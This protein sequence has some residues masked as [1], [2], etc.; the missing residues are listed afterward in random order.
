M[1]AALYQSLQQGATLLTA[2]RYLAHVLTQ[3]YAQAAQAQGL[4]VWLTPRILP[5]STY[6]RLAC[7]QQRELLVNSPRLLSEQQALAVWEHVV[8]EFNDARP[9]SDRLLNPSQAA[10]HAQRSWQRLHQYQL[11]LQRLRDYPIEETRVFSDWA[12]RF[13][14]R[15]ADKG[16]LDSARFASFLSDQD[17]Q[18]D[19]EL[20]VYG[21]DQITPEMQHLLQRWAAQGASIKQ[22]ELEKKQAIASVLAVPEAG[23]ELMQAA[24]WARVRIESGMQRVA[25]VVPGLNQQATQVQRCFT[26]VFAPAQR[27]I[28]VE[29]EP[30]AFHVVATPALSGYPL[31]HHALLLLELMQGKVDALV[32]GQLLRSPYIA[33]YEDEA[34]VRALLDLKVR[35]ESLDYWFSHDLEQ[36][37]LKRNCNQLAACLQAASQYL[38]SNQQRALPSEWTERLTMLL[39]LSGWSRGRSLDSAEQQTL[40]KFHQLLGELSALDELLGRIDFKLAISTLHDACNAEHFAPESVD[41]AVT[42][43]DVD[44]IA[45]MHFDAIWVMGLHA[46]EWP[47]APEP[48]P[49]LPV[50][51]QRSYGI[52]EASAGQ[53]LQLARHKLQR[54]VNAADEVILSWPEKD[55][56]A[57]L[58]RSPLLDIYDNGVIA[59]VRSGAVPSLAQQIF[60]ARP[61]LDVYSDNRAP[62]QN[63]GSAK[64]G[65]RILELQSRCPFRAQ[66]ELRLH[67]RPV[68]SV[69]PA[70]EAT[71]RGKLV[72]AVL[73]EVWRQL[74][75]SERLRE[76]VLDDFYVEVHAIALRHAKEVIGRSSVHR[77]RLAELEAELST[78]WI[79]N[80]LQLE[81]ARTPFRVQQTE[82]NETYELAGMQI[83]IQ[84]DRIDELSDGSR[85]LIDYKTGTGNN[86]GDWLD[87]EPGRP[88]SP[89]LPL[90]ALAHQQQL[91]GI[92]FAVLAP[93]KT[94]FRGLAATDTIAT[95]IKDYTQLRPEQKP[96]GI[97]T[98]EALLSHWKTVLNE[99]AHQYLSGVADVDPLKN[100]CTY[101]HLRSLCRVHEL[102]QGI[103][104]VEEEGGDA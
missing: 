8:N 45:G 31:V 103:E 81:S 78:Q 90:Y 75:D 21:F 85:L 69:S 18:P 35:D 34:S 54:L 19:T 14:S 95:G 2:S 64:G 38:K 24:Q 71:D 92:T 5:W 44:S 11:P 26:N 42:V 84:L 102:L 47:P 27:R 17:F 29:H 1:D 50:E 79:M 4:A 67:A 88:R 58:R 12:E 98:W 13:I 91:S 66:A 10:R 86:T 94:E 52:P 72:H 101:C 80:L 56:D 99:L 96:D 9:Q 53:C 100:E 7:Q 57:E 59:D 40:V 33:G 61:K 25:V 89:Q 36:L 32:I 20:L 30:V 3:E 62:Q 65:T 82:Q 70:V 74:K 37:A 16:W 23:V 83:R 43:I 63:P 46:G 55:A 48:D 28:N 104:Q 93:G 41:Q 97:D 39:K 76:M 73:D 51:L 77:Q 6:L 68:P 22:P 15:T 49:F 87:R 60:Q